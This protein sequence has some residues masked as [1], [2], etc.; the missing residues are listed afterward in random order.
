MAKNMQ[1]YIRISHVYMK[2]KMFRTTHRPS[3]GAQNSRSSLWFCIRE[4]L[5]DSDSVQQPQRPQPF[6]Y[7]KPEAARAV[8]SS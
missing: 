1:K 3:S 2:L 4:R 6:M 7:A 8:L 5:L